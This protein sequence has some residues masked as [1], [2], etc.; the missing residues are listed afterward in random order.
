MAIE[1]PWPEWCCT[2]RFEGAD[3]GF[4]IPARDEDELSRRLR[5]IGMTARIDG[6]LYERIP[7]FP[8][9]GLYVRAKTFLFNLFG[10]SA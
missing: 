4:T 10:K 5:A 2:Y 9:S 6:I 3:Y 8:G 7:V 1:K